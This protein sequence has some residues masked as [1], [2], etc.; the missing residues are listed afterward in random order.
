MK[1]RFMAPANAFG[2]SNV[3]PILPH[4][5]LT[6]SISTNESPKRD[7][8]HRTL[9]V[10]LLP[11]RPVKRLVGGDL[12]H[13]VEVAPLTFELLTPLDDPQ[14][15]ERLA[16]ALAPPLLGLVVR[17]ARVVQERRRDGIR[18]RR[19]RQLDAA[20]DLH[21]AAVPVAAV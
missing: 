10:A 20:R 9:R 13:H 16:V 7:V 1:P 12:R 8:D 5:S 19:L 21:D 2:G 15:L 14:V 17:V 11:A 3:S 4:T 6:T 18:V